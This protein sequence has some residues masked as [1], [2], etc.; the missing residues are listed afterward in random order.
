[1]VFSIFVVC[2]ISSENEFARIDMRTLLS[3]IALC[4]L[5][6]VSLK[7]QTMVTTGVQYGKK[8]GVTYM[9]PRTEILLK[10]K[11]TKHS[12]EP[13]EF[14]RYASRYMRLNDV[15]QE[16]ETYWTLDD[17]SVQVYGVPDADN[18]Y[19]VEMK[20][21]TVAPLMELTEDGIVRSINMPF[22]GITTDD[23]ASSDE[24][25]IQDATLDP[26]QYMTEEM[27]MA[28]S[29]AKMAELVSREIF[30]LRESKRD[31]IS[32]NAD[33]TP[34]DGGQLQIMLD[35][36]NKQEAAL[37]QMFSGV[38]RTETHTTELH[39][40]PSEMTAEVVF[41]FSK[42]LGLVDK[43]DLSGEPV[44]MSIKNENTIAAPVEEATDDKKKLDGIAYN[45][46]GQA[47]VTLTYDHKPL[48]T[49]EVALTQFG[50]KEYLAALLFNR[51]STT[52]V[53]FDVNTGGLIKIDRE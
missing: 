43:D 4:L 22:S 39:I 9:L 10:V 36:L 2:E 35:N 11:V 28:N 41:R 34:K 44:T 1:M 12:Y 25:N 14:C 38:E 8:Y 23:S 24:E 31:L 49:E 5:S 48:I 33:N 26:R 32:G 17:V 19:F 40:E 13:G 53:L 15:K 42:K 45:V 27:L 46:P 37:T 20:D 6:A 51:N 18:I 50:S 7:A 52:K 16:A 30:S 29:H 21:R 47:E 3:T